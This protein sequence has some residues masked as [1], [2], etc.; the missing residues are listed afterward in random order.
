MT[1]PYCLRLTPQ[2][3]AA[4][5]QLARAHDMSMA[6]YI[7]FKVLD[8]A[9]RRSSEQPKSQQDQSLAQILSMLGQSRYANNLNQLAKAANLGTLVITPDVK[10]QIDESYKMILWVRRMLISALG[11]KP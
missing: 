6:A 7:R 11:L 5:A 10:A 4:I 9:Q 8:P 2:E 3:R 1:S